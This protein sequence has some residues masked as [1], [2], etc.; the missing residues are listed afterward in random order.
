MRREANEEAYLEIEKKGF[1]EETQSHAQI[2]LQDEIMEKA[3]REAQEKVCEYTEEKIG[4]C[5]SLKELQPMRNPCWSRY[6]S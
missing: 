4:V 1:E 2:E 5:T 6:N 3:Q